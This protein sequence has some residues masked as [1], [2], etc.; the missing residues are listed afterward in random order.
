MVCASNLHS[1]MSRRFGIYLLAAT[2]FVSFAG[3]AACAGPYVGKPEKLKTP[4]KKKKPEKT[5]EELAAEAA[6]A[7]VQWDDNCRANFFDDPHNRRYAKRARPLT[8]AA[9]SLLGDADELEGAER[10]ETVSQAMS[11]LR[12]ALKQ[13]PYGPEQTY[14]LAVAYAM[15]LK[16]KCAVMLLE[17]LTE[18]E[19]HPVVGAQAT[20]VISRA[21]SDTAFDGFRKDADAAL[22]R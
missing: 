7:D 2:L 3:I 4:R 11:K 9:D 19:N 10:V 14:K 18:L 1:G 15:V 8:A 17:R 6:V 21:M 20:R 16:K 22:G 5:D 12:N 13:D